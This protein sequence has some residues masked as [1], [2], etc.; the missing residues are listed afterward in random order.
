MQI[1]RLLAAVAWIALTHPF[2]VGADETLRFTD[3]SYADAALWRPQT[4]ADQRIRYGDGGSPLQFGDL[5]L[6]DTAAPES[7]FPVIAF[8]HGGAWRAQWSKDYSEALVEALTAEGFVTW[9]IEYRRLGNRGGGYPGTFNDVADGLDHLR[10]LAENI[11]IDLERVIVIGHSAGGHLALWLAGRHRLGPS[12][13]L[14]RKDPL[15]INGVISIAGVNDFELSLSLGNRTDM[16][17]LVGVESVDAGLERL[18]EVDPGRL[19]P[20][21]V[22]QVQVIGDRDGEWRLE[23]NARYEEKARAAGDRVRTLV[24]PGANHMDV[25]DA[26]SGVATLLAAEAQRLLASDPPGASD[27]ALTDP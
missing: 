25:A 11:P 4:V 15:P 2:P 23:M 24:L 1:H 16:L 17:E 5:R 18:G 6:P 13:P 27:P 14:Y 7:G 8:L 26:R 9:D 19:L 20:L 22:P 3:V 10:N 12:S 21:G